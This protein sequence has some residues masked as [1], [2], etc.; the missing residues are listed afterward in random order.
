MVPSVVPTEC[1]FD[2]QQI[3]QLIIDSLHKRWAYS[4]FKVCI[5]WA[6]F[7]DI[8]RVSFDTP[9]HIC[10]TCIVGHLLEAQLDRS[11]LM[12]TFVTLCPTMVKYYQLLSHESFPT[13]CHARFFPLDC[14][15][16]VTVCQLMCVNNQ[17]LLDHLVRVWSIVNKFLVLLSLLSLPPT[18]TSS[19]KLSAVS[20]IFG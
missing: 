19:M 4:N 9:P 10:K 20:P 5:S 3:G 7:W 16:G 14:P 17:Q 15:I 18:N 6:G 2:A 13:L 11:V 1:V 12:L 8:S